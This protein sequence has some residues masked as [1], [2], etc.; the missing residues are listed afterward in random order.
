[1]G[2]VF[3]KLG[4]LRETKEAIK[5]AIIRKG[6]N[7]SDNATFRE[8]ANV[9]DQLPSDAETQEALKEILKDPEASGLSSELINE[10]KEIE[11]QIH[12]AIIQKGV[13]LETDAPLNTYP[14]AVSAIN[15]YPSDIDPSMFMPVED[16]E[17]CKQNLVD[18]A[19]EG[20]IYKAIF[21]YYGETNRTF[22]IGGVNEYAIK[23]CDG[24]YYSGNT[25]E[26]SEVNHTWDDDL[27][28]TSRFNGKKVRWFIQ[29][30]K[31][32]DSFI[33]DYAAAYVCID[34]S[35][36]GESLLKPMQ[37]KYYGVDG[38]NGAC[39]KI[40]KNISLLGNVWPYHLNFILD[41][42][43]SDLSAGYFFANDKYL[44]KYP[45]L[46][47]THDL[48]NIESMF[49]MSLVKKAPFFDMSNVKSMMN[50]FG[51]CYLLESV[52]LYDTSKVEDAGGAFY[53]CISLHQVPN[54]N[55]ENVKNAQSIFSSCYTLYKMPICNYPKLENGASMFEMCYLLREIGTISIP[56]CTNASRMFYYC[57][58]L[59]EINISDNSSL[60]YT[61]Y[62]FAYSSHLKKVGIINMNQVE[63][64]DSMFKECYSLT[65][66]EL[67]NVNCSLDLSDSTKL[68]PETLVNLLNN[69]KQTTTEKTLTLGA[70]NLAKLTDEQ[71]AI[72]TNKGWI[73]A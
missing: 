35:T 66:V 23:T 58:S 37:V 39:L 9:I 28:E 22:T 51:T 60:K 7:V 55:F 10:I 42:D 72:A 1:M 70:D 17:K 69:L 8:Y 45:K 56:V 71:K 18:D 25:A 47:N 50:F 15:Y 67:R 61:K 41:I 73:L 16:M 44:V 54:L 13:P 59:Y 6:A 12:G 40:S 38:I 33:N 29:Y 2:S 4:Y 64:A 43:F 14:D 31:T 11:N 3:E 19:H 68:T 5:N 52:P 21:L 36:V 20:Y 30:T 65:T 62:M 32:E 26:T 46:M 27:C 49:M 53:F 24:A 57:V 48:T 63:D 34:T